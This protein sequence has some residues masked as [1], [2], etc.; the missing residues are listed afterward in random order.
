MRTGCLDRKLLFFI[1]LLLQLLVL[2]K[3]HLSLPIK[4]EGCGLCNRE[5]KRDK[6]LEKKYSLQDLISVINGC[7]ESVTKS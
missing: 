6:I 1:L 3:Q 5:G 7:K 2:P 4:R